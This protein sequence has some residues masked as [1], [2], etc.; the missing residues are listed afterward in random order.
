MTTKP[1]AP[2]GMHKTCAC[3]NDDCHSKRKEAEHDLAFQQMLSVA[4]NKKLE[5]ALALAEKN[6]KDAERLEWLE[7]LF[8]SRWNGV[9]DSGSQRN[10]TIDGPW[11]HQVAKMQGNTFRAAIDAAIEKEP[12]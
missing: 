12:K 2:V 6:A 7:N 1:P 11:R 5:A 8:S 10:W 4:K 3:C 9:I